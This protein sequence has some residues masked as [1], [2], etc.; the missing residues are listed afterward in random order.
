MQE[1]QAD[2][3]SAL[4][5]GAVARITGVTV[6]TLRKWEDRYGA[7]EPTR[8]EGGKRIYSRTDLE[9]LALIKRLADAGLSLPGIA[10]L[11]LADLEKQWQE[12]SSAAASGSAR[13]RSRVRVAVVGEPMVAQSAEPSGVLNVV[14]S[15]A[16]IDRVA[17]ALAGTPVDMLLIECPT[18]QQDTQAAVAAAMQRLRAGAA[19]VVYRFAATSAL[20]ALHAA[21]IATLRG[22]VDAG[23]LE[24]ATIDLVHEHGLQ[25]DPVPADDEEYIAPPRLAP[26]LIARIARSA[27]KVR[28]ECPRHLAEIIVGLRA[29]ERYSAECEDRN[30]EDQAL[31]HYL[32]RCAATARALFEDAI[33]MV[34]RAEGIRLD[35]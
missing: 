28:C 6:H 5:I 26:E 20:A 7:V 19:L 32:W 23:E 2:Q 30:P 27:P 31:H 3:P 13:T 17:A 8:T 24:R 10:R 25:S 9:R 18:L 29:F 14:A 34:A 21:G 11:P 15:G 4:K 12:V 35:D 33:E 22:P 16:D 1:S